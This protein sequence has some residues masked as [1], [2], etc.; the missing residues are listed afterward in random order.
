MLMYFINHAYRDYPATLS[1]RTVHICCQNE[2]QTTRLHGGFMAPYLPPCPF[3]I[4]Y[5][6][7]GRIIYFINYVCNSVFV[8]ALW[9]LI[10]QLKNALCKFYAC[11]T[12]GIICIAMLGIWILNMIFNSHNA[13]I[14]P[15]EITARFFVFYFL[16][17]Q[18]SR[19]HKNGQLE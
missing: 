8:E 16:L 10:Y 1:I 3:Q 2:L 17:W 12:D 15:L 13:M 6:P 7:S 5:V 18:P 14:E 9:Q 19:A 4:E 11:L